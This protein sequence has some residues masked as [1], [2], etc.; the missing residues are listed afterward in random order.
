MQFSPIALPTFLVGFAIAC[1]TI[2]HKEHPEWP[3]VGPVIDKKFREI[4]LKANFPESP[5]LNAI[6]ELQEDTYGKVVRIK[7]LT[8][9]EVEDYFVRWMGEPYRRFKTIKYGRM[10]LYSPK[11]IG[12]AIQLNE[13]KKREILI[14]ALRSPLPNP[15]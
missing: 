9:S 6:Y 4:G 14:I 8:F 5:S 10:T 12:I 3:N 1:S 13:V 15:H 7:G 11:G 2:D